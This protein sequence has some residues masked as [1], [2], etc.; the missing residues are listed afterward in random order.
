MWYCLLTY[1]AIEGPAQAI[2]VW[3]QCCFVRQ[4]ALTWRCRKRR[5]ASVIADKDYYKPLTFPVSP[6]R[7]CRTARTTAWTKRLWWYSERTAGR[8]GWADRHLPTPKTCSYY[9]FS[10]DKSSIVKMFFGAVWNNFI[11]SERRDALLILGRVSIKFN[12]QWN[13]IS[14]LFIII[15]NSNHILQQYAKNRYSI[16]QTI[17]TLAFLYIPLCNFPH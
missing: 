9:L 6:V 12:V 16:C 7:W 13:L 3:D 15:Y 11:L 17:D 14:I 8:P 4:M 10:S 1:E 5:Q 2:Q